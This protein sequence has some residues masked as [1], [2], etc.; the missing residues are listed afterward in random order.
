MSRPICLP[1]RR[2]VGR[3]QQLAGDSRP[4]A[5][6][7]HEVFDAL[8]FDA[9][10]CAG[11]E[12]A[13]RRV[14]GGVDKA[15]HVYP[16]D[17]FP[18]LAARFPEA[19]ERLVAGSIGENLSLAGID[20][21]DVH[22]GDVFALGAVRLEVC[23]PRQPCWKI[24]ARYGVDGLTAHIAESGRTGWYCRVV[25][26]GIAQPQD[27]FERVHHAAAAPTLASL[28]STWRAHRPDLATLETLAACPAL[29]VNWRQKIAERLDWLARQT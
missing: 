27:R 3:V 1:A 5:I 8:A 11:D 21:H 2:F 20:E 10:G 22:L 29:S 6:V 9:N 4:S 26:G 14:H 16:A 25:A 28:W 15:V 12:Q 19:A 18:I 7:K 13:D 17:H 24:D 23:Q